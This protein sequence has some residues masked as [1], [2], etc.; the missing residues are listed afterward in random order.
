VAHPLSLPPSRLAP[1][2]HPQ[3]ATMIGVS[4][5]LD[6]LI[7]LSPWIALGVFWVLGE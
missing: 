1:L 6:V 4:V 7:V 5:P 3:E 2:V